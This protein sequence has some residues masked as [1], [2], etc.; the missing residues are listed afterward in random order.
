MQADSYRKQP[1]RR[2]IPDTSIP[3]LARMAGPVVISLLA[4]N[5]IG[6]IDT[7][8]LGRLGVAELGGTSIA[9][10]VY[11]SIFTIGFGLSSGT[12]IIISHKY[13][14]GQDRSIGNVL[15]NSIMLLLGAAL[16]AILI[17]LPVGRWA[18]GTLLSS[19]MVAEAAMEYWDYRM[20]GFLFVFASSSMRSFFVGIGETKVL[21]YN[22][23]VMSA[24]NILLDWA[25]IFGHLGLPAL[26]IRGAAIASV[27]AEGASLLFYIFYICHRV[28]RKRFGLGLRD[29]LRWDR[30]VAKSLLRLSYFLMLQA[31]M[32]QSVWTLFFFM[33]ESLGEVALGVASICRSVYNIIFISIIAYGTAVRT[34]TGQL[35]GADAA[36]LVLPYLRRAALLS[37]GTALVLAGGVSLFPEEVLSIFTDDRALIAAA[38]PTMRVLCLAFL[39]ASGGGM[40]FHA[41]GGVGATRKVFHIELSGNAFYLL[42]ALATIYLAQGPVALCFS[43][44]IFYFAIISLR[45][46]LF[47]RSGRWHRFHVQ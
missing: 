34:T 21:T 13:G 8:F 41:V 4:Q 14:A 26:G 9:S 44:E 28:D 40:Y 16:V 3:A 45:S 25:L 29:L 30:G 12:Q 31:L 39:L 1:I 2:E 27:I 42:Y 32:S 18:F 33:L 35:M 17:A 7:A 10:L 47:M 46:Y 20:I 23:L 36:D 43:V 22:S 11:F 37:F 24:V 15:G 38:V 6:A 5:L 19:H